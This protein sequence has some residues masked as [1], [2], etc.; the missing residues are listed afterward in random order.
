[1]AILSAKICSNC[2]RTVPAECD[3]RTYQIADWPRLVCKGSDGECFYN[4]VDG[5]PKFSVTMGHGS[6]FTFDPVEVV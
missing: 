5:S 1:M 4:A 3:G 2:K 6:M